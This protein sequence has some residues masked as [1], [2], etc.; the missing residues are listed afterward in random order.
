MDKQDE[1]RLV[2]LPADSPFPTLSTYSVAAL[3]L[4]DGEE[5]LGI[6]LTFSDHTRGIAVLS[7][8]ALAN[9]VEKIFKNAELLGP[10]FTGPALGVVQQFLG[11][12]VICPPCSEAKHCQCTNPT[13]CPCGHRGECSVGK[14]E[15]KC[16]PKQQ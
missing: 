14:E 1:T 3:E 4:A 5:R 12:I 8:E 11:G 9:F 16:P 7:P 13:T 2:K 10:E 6:G 15:C